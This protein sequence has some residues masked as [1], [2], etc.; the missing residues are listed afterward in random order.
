MR[1][2]PV[3]VRGEDSGQH[4]QEL[5]AVFGGVKAPSSEKELNA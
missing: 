4:L 2:D 5:M 3:A 1:P